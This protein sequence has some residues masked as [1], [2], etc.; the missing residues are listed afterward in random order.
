[1]ASTRPYW[2]LNLPSGPSWHE[3]W[4]D[5]D[6]ELDLADFAQDVRGGDGTEQCAYKGSILWQDDRLGSLLITNDDQDDDYSVVQHKVESLRFNSL[7]KTTYVLARLKMSDVEQSDFIFGA[8]KRSTTP[9]TLISDGL[10]FSSDDGDSYLDCSRAFNAAT[11]PDDY[12]QELAAY[13]MT[14]DTYMVLCLRV[15]MDSVTAAKGRA[16]YYVDNVPV[17]DT[18][19]LSSIVNDEELAIGVALQNGAAAAKTLTLDGIGYL[20]ER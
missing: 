12:S 4:W 13:T 7:G 8:W 16:T 6:S 20:Q 15:I 11:R 19:A 2:A 9:F 5:F 3:K 1:M 14:N 18:P 10:F 17:Y